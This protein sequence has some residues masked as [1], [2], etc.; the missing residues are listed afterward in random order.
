[1]RERLI[2][3][4]GEYSRLYRIVGGGGE[5]RLPGKAGGARPADIFHGAV[6][7]V[8]RTT[9]DDVAVRVDRARDGPIASA[10]VDYPGTFRLA[11]L[12][13][14]H[15]VAGTAGCRGCAM[16]GGESP[17][18]DVVEAEDRHEERR[19]PRRR[20]HLNAGG[21]RWWGVRWRSANAR[22]AVARLAVG[23]VAS[24]QFAAGVGET[25]GGCSANVVF[26]GKLA[27]SIGD[28]RP[29]PVRLGQRKRPS[30]GRGIGSVLRLAPVHVE[31]PTVD[32]KRD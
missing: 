24:A 29:R 31:A 30:E 2:H 28:V 12:D 10:P 3:G 26:A 20:S 7:G 27:D 23:G 15:A 25:A 21:I 11:R 19:C 17:H 9:H 4:I 18:L 13:C 1:M 5:R 32:T 14:E 8:V 6:D 22:L 16:G